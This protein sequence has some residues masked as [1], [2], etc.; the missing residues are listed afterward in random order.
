MDRPDLKTCLVCGDRIGVYEPTMV[1]DYDLQRQTS[2]AR[3]PDL[4]DDLDELM[5]HAECARSFVGHPRA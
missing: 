1:L 5:A 3:E 2:F 4:E